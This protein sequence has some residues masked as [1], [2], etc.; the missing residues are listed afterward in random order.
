M[1]ANEELYSIGF[2]SQTFQ[3]SPSALQRE[4]EAIGIMP[5][6]HL[7]DIAHFS[8]LDVEAMRRHLAKEQK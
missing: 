2:L 1:N 4:F 3:R 7:N 5:R 6:L 8:R